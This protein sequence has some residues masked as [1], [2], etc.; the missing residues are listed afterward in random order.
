MTSLLEKLHDIEGL[1]PV[2]RW[3]L[4]I[5]WWIALVLG[6]LAICTLAC[7]FSYWLAYRRSWKAD[8][9][10]KLT[11]LEKHLSEETARETIVILSEYLRRI[12]LKRFPRKEC[13]G[14]VGKDWLKWLA[15]HDPKKFE[16]EKRG[17]L[18]I[19]VPYAPVN[20]GL[21][22]KEIKDLIQAVRG[23]VR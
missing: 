9:L 17:L 2:S 20:H 13:A 6:V 14:L 1:D 10:K 5:G 3:P 7:F 23:W 22:T 18:L 11:S 12:V 16:W 15:S 19:E 21:S 8:A 4:A